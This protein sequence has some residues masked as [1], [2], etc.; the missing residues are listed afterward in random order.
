MQLDDDSLRLRL[1][2]GSA[3]IRVV[4]RGRGWPASNSTTPQARVRLQQPGRLRVDAERVRDTS[5]SACS[6]APPW[7]RAAAPS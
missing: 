2:Y 5:A 6:T 1:H 7:S 4:K 3:S